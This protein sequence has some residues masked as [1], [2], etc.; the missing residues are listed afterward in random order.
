MEGNTKYNL[1]E[2]TAKFGEDVIALVQSI[3]ENTINKPLIS[4]LVRAATSVGANYMEADAGESKKDFKHKIGI[5]KKEAKETMYWCQMMAK[6]V[7]EKINICRKLWR[8][9]QELTMIFSAIIRS[10]SR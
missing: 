3:P 5:C 4:Q 8:E 7:P 1:S 9:A 10:C 2:R 6:V